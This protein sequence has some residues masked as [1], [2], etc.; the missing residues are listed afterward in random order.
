MKIKYIFL[1]RHPGEY[2]IAWIIENIELI[3]VFYDL[4]WTHNFS[5]HK[6]VKILSLIF[7]ILTIHYV[8]IEICNKDGITNSIYW[9]YQFK[10]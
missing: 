10:S 9:F 6:I 8:W 7:Y 5:L 2:N 3:Y 4:A 1:Y